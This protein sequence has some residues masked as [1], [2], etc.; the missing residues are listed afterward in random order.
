MCS[1]AKDTERS[2]SLRAD[3]PGHAPSATRRCFATN[4]ANADVERVLTEVDRLI[5][6]GVD[7][8]YFIDEI[9][10]VGKNVRTLLEGI[11]ER[12]VKIGF[13]TRIDLWDEETLDLL[14]R[15]RLHLDG[16]R[17]RVDHGSRARRTEQEL[18]HRHRAH[19]RIADLRAS[20]G[21][22]GCRQT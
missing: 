21:F 7:Y 15:A 5:A 18:P 6:R 11:A 19:H 12:H 13:Q 14:G 9:F 3:A 8:V 16:V 22:P 17:H 1:S 4:S 10:G 20:S 2:W